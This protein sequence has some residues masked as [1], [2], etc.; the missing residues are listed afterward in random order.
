MAMYMSD[1]RYQQNYLND[2]LYRFATKERSTAVKSHRNVQKAK[3]QRKGLVDAIRTQ[4]VTEGD[5]LVSDHDNDNFSCHGSLYKNTS[6]RELN[7]IDMYV[8]LNGDTLLWNNWNKTLVRQAQTQTALG[9]RRYEAGGPVRRQSAGFNARLSTTFARVERRYISQSASLQGRGGSRRLPSFAVAGP[10]S[11]VQARAW[12]KSLVE[13]VLRGPA[14]AC[15]RC[16]VVT[17]G[18]G[19]AISGLGNPP[20]TFDVIPAFL[21]KRDNV[22][23]HVIPNGSQWEQ[24]ATETEQAEID[25]LDE[26]FP[27]VPGQMLLSY[28]QM[29]K[30]IKTIKKDPDHK[31]KEKYGVT[32]FM[33]EEAVKE[34]MLSSYW[35][36]SR[37]GNQQ[38]FFNALGKLRLKV[39]S[40]PIGGFQS[41]RF[42]H[43][44]RMSC[45]RNDHC[46]LSLTPADLQKYISS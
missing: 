39:Q 21:F 43:A 37:Q 31:W 42:S 22:R 36:G 19:V 26:A 3:N 25:A 27:S 23:Y 12:M 14:F 1:Q 20:R 2:E 5:Y 6:I 30:L 13:T 29:V 35:H 17:T 44:A 41:I 45:L 34:A 16:T 7:D 8:V 4:I 18:R 46:S 40:L 33:V 9:V 11:A 32:S 10:V 15:S 28:R 24:V 38:V